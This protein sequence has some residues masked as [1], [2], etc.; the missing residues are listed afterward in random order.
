M[1]F[2]NTRIKTVSSKSVEDQNNN[3]S[4]NLK[5]TNTYNDNSN[6][7][8]KE[9]TTYIPKR[10]SQN[11]PETN[12]QDMLDFK[13]N[14]NEQEQDQEQEQENEHEHE[15]NYESDHTRRY[16]KKYTQEIKG[17][18]RTTKTRHI[19]MNDEKMPSLFLKANSCFSIFSR[20]SS[21]I[22]RL[23]SLLAPAPIIKTYFSLGFKINLFI[24]LLFQYN[25][26][27][28]PCN[29]IRRNNIYIF[30]KQFM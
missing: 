19:Q 12:Y 1:K 23:S 8:I 30:F 6:N 27:I 10:F 24:H 14:N 9:T 22:G 18:I 3:E 15:H 7:L 28:F 13:N 5:I 26:I 21:C 25:I 2:D 4:I 29:T 17:S 16:N 20:I 11:L